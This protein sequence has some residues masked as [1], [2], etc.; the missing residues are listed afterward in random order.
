MTIGKNITLLAATTD[1]ADSIEFEVQ[2][3]RSVTVSCSPNLGVGEDA[4]IQF[5]PD[6]GTTW[7]NYSDDAEVKLSSIKNAVNL[8][9]P[10]RFRVAKDATS[11]PTALYLQR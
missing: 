3:G 9:G 2:D 11:S 6:N 8:I 4:N 5:S 1:A 10:A 7:V